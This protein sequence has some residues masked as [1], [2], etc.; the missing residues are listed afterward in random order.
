MGKV[1]AVLASVIFII[2]VIVFTIGELNKDNEEEPETYRWMRIFAF[3]LVVM[4]AVCAIK[5]G[6]F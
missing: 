6:V 1:L 2:A 3:V 4:A 5:S